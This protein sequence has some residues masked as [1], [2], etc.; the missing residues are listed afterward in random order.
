[1]DVTL[2]DGTVVKGIP[3]G[4]TKA[5]LAEKLKANGHEVPPEWVRRSP[6]YMSES[7]NPEN[8]GLLKAMESVE[9]GIYEAGGKV[10]DV[11]S[12]MGAAPGVAAG[13]GYLTNIG[14]NAIGGGLGGDI[15]KVASVPLSKLSTW[16]ARE[17]MGSALK[18]SAMQWLK[19]EG[20]VAVNT[21]LEKGL[22]VSE[23]GIISLRKELEG[24]QQQV[25]AAIAKSGGKIPKADVVK[26][27]EE[28]ATQFKG[29]TGEIQDLRTIKDVVEE[30]KKAPSVKKLK[31]I[32]VQVAQRM[33]TLEYRRLDKAYGALGDAEETARKGT[34]RG[35]K[36]GIEKA[37]PEVKALNAEE[38]K[39]YRTLPVVERRAMMEI[40]R[41]P[42]GLALLTHNPKVA[43]IFMGDKSSAFK[44]WLANRINQYSNSIT[45]SLRTLG[46]T[47]VSL[48]EIGE[49]R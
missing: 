19:G 27:I 28:A 24:L 2:P 25:S 23:G 38:Q 37:A 39:I 49:Q 10:T 42:G 16:S 48:A 13:A 40:N 43:A 41:N 35:L 15:V 31:D 12:R 26:A 20:D 11:A 33:K 29:G 47:G 32:P 45:P 9:K 7:D 36:E 21:M 18:P 5:Q 17:L 44:S 6:K 30:F 22:N 8:V 1:M 4:T 46:Q 34:A 14:L 3:D